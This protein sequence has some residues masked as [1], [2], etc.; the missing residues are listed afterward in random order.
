MTRYRKFL[1]FLFV[2]VLLLYVNCASRGDRL[3]DWETAGRL[4]KIRVTAYDERGVFLR[5]TYFVFESAPGSSTQWSEF[6]AVRDDDRPTIPRNQ[7]R[8]VNDEVAYV[9]MD[10]MY[11]VT[12]DGG[13]NWSVWDMTRDVP[14]WQWSKY[15]IIQDVSIEPDGKGVIRLRSVAQNSVKSAEFHTED[16]GRHWAEK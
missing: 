8:F 11:A 13:K 9:F 16:F 12:T 10:W 7:V 15:G 4:F 14:G 1:A 2:S 5:G 3:E 6:M